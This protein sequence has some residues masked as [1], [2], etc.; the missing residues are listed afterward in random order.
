MLFNVDIEN[1]TNPLSIKATF[2]HQHFISNYF[3][4]NSND[5]TIIYYFNILRAVYIGDTFYVISNGGITS[6]DLDDLN[7]IKDDLL[8][9]TVYS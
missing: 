8:L 4:L 6:Y 2:S 9:L 5:Y 3:T 1:D 7:V